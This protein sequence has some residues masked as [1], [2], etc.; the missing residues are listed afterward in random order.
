MHCALLQSAHAKH[1]Q[2]DQ[3]HNLTR[4]V[5]YSHLQSVV[6]TLM[7]TYQHKADSVSNLS[8]FRVPLGVQF[9]KFGKD[10]LDCG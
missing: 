8:S 1:K 2:E 9:I 10:L 4:I 7:A 6:D 3:S 5:S